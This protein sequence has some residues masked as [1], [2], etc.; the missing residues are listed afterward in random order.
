MAVIVSETPGIV[1]SGIIFLF[2]MILLFGYCFYLFLFVSWSLMKKDEY[3]VGYS[4]EKGFFCKNTMY[5][6]STCL[7]EMI[8]SRECKISKA[9]LRSRVDSHTEVSLVK[10]GGRLFYSRGPLALKPLLFIC[11]GFFI[12]W[13]IPWADHLILSRN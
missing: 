10:V 9:I 7:G 5:P 11:L 3:L 12:S 6:V 4:P 13:F 2:S 8:M 1:F